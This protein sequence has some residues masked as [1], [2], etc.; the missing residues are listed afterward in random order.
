MRRWTLTAA[1]L[2]LFAGLAFAAVKAER[3]GVLQ[4]CSSA[5]ATG[6]SP[7]QVMADGSAAITFQYVGSGT[8]DLK[9][10]NSIDNGNTWFDV[11][12][13]SCT[14]CPSPTAFKV[15]TP[16]GLY[17]SNVTTCTAC[18]YGIAWRWA[19]YGK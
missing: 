8:T 17:R 14:G 13:A 12:A 6:A 1:A 7:D 15:S 9:I 4:Q 16:V 5:C 2:L 3:F 10:Q 11:T 19:G 18:T